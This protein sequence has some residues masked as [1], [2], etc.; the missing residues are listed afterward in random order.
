VRYS[1]T[2]NAFNVERRRDRPAKR[3]IRTHPRLHHRPLP[4]RV[5]R[6]SQHNHRNLA[7]SLRLNFRTRRITVRSLFGISGSIRM[8]DFDL[9]GGDWL[10][11]GVWGGPGEDEVGA[12]EGGGDWGSLVRHISRNNL[13]HIR[14]LSPPLS[15]LDAILELISTTANNTRT[16]C[17]L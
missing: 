7:K 5:R 16:N 4:N 3:I 11:A 10:G 1:L 2:K 12:G 15:I 6:R 9:V 13:C 8:S 17:H 14:V